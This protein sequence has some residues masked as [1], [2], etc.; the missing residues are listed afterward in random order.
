MLSFASRFASPSYSY[1]LTAVPTLPTMR[2]L[3]DL[4]RD[5]EYLG[6]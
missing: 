2:Q 5:R 3:R 1:Q 4:D 6:R